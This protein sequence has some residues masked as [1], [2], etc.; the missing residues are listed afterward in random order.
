MGPILPQGT[1]VIVGSGAAATVTLPAGAYL[2]HLEAKGAGTFTIFGGDAITSPISLAF[3][4]PYTAARTGTLTIV[5][6]AGITS[7]MV[8]YVRPGA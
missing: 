1:A 5:F 6:G 4:D 3:V 8:R 7:S 2:T